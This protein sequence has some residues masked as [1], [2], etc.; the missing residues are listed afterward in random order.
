MKVMWK[1]LSNKIKD[2]FIRYLSQNLCFETPYKTY[3]ILIKT[4]AK[5]LEGGIDY[6][7]KVTILN[8]NLK[9]APGLKLGRIR[10]SMINTGY[11][12]CVSGHMV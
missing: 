7:A 2:D 9:G 10:Y 3:T 11:V 4:G 6:G 12:H 1:K 5:S 8:F